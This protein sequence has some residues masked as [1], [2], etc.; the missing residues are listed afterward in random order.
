MVAETASRVAALGLTLTLTDAALSLLC[1][2]GF[3]LDQGARQLRRSVISLLEDPLADALLTGRAAAGDDVVVDARGG[4][5]VLLVSGDAR[6]G[7]SVQ[8]AGQGV[9]VEGFP[10]PV[11]V[12]DAPV[13]PVSASA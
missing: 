5:M 8:S 10:A 13:V 3:A 7:P 4:E 11:D 1:A 2:T 9:E 6:A 12:V